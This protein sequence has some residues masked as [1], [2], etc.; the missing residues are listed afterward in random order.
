MRLLD[1]YT[2]MNFDEMKARKAKSLLDEPFPPEEKEPVEQAQSA[3]MSLWPSLGDPQNDVMSSL[4]EADEAE[5]PSSKSDTDFFGETLLALAGIKGLGF[6]T[7]SKIAALLDNHLERIWEYSAEEL[8]SKSDSFK[9]PPLD[10]LIIQI[11]SEREQLLQHGRERFEKLSAQNIKIIPAWNL[12][13]SLQ[14]IPDSPHW[15]F[16]QGDHRLLYYKPAVA[17]VGT[18]KPTKDGINAAAAVA[19]HIAAYPVVLVSG[20]AEGIDETAHRFS[21]NSDTKN[22]AF[23]GHGIDVIFP[24]STQ[25]IREKIIENNGAIVSEYLPGE[26]YRKEYFVARNRLQAGI[27]D[28]IIPVEA[29]LKGGTAHTVRFAKQYGRPLMGVRWNGVNGILPE[30]EKEGAPI[31]DIFSL[32]GKVQF[33]QAIRTLSERFGKSTYALSEAER[34]LLAEMKQRDLRDSDVER[35]IKALQAF[36]QGEQDVERH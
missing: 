29:N 20:L 6:R 13:P 1:Y 11:A 12:P 14:E 30:L 9:A 28:L 36:L 33:D 15:L 27:S 31:V 4:R 19:R 23:L 35:L 26:S 18:R 10:K 3:Q 22:I 34:K 8:L 17:V 7:L 32:V 16:V 5:A 21:L 24:A 25:W 2:G